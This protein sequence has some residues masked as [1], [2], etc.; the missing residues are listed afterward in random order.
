MK[1]KQDVLTQTVLPYSH[2]NVTR[3]G[4]YL[5]NGVRVGRLD[6]LT[7]YTHHSE[8]QRTAPNNSS[9][10]VIGGCLTIAWIDVFDSSRWSVFTY[11]LLRNGRY[12]FSY[13]IAT[14]V[15]AKIRVERR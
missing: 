14:A 4:N 2:Y 12:I 13:C 9:I 3:W 15:H 1:Q 11:S 7:S 5:L 10:V 8:P 6:L